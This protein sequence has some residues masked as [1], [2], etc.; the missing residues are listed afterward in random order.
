M[1]SNDRFS[2]ELWSKLSMENISNTSNGM[3]K[4][5]QICIG[6]LDKLAP[7]KKKY[8]RG[9]N[10]PFMNKALAQAHMRRNRLQNRFLRNRSQV[11]RINY[12][13]QHN[14]CKSSEKKQKPILCKS[15]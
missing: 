11:N 10:M 4:I 12:I 15:K 6:V 5:L 3:E 1:F 13:K 2:G 9:N 7:Q 14:Y 8:N